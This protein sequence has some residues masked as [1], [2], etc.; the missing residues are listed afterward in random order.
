M[1]S[2]A[3]RPAPSRAHASVATSRPDG[4]RAC[5]ATAES[6]CTAA[7]GGSRSSWPGAAAAS[8]G[9]EPRSEAVAGRLAQQRPGD[10]E[11]L[12]LARALIDLRHLGV[13]VVALGGELLRVA[14]A[15]EH[16]DRL[17]GLAAGDGRCEELGLGALYGVGLPGRLEPGGPPGQRAR[18]L[19]LGL[20]VGEPMLDRLEATDRA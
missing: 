19:D 13:A 18:R 8:P 16:L 11:P 7:L 6:K 2:A 9:P 1:G 3:A 17:A 14:V 12:D 4:R 15:A 5:A 10:H 20:H